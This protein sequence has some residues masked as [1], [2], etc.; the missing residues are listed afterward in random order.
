[1]TGSNRTEPDSGLLNRAADVKKGSEPEA[2]GQR[3]GRRGSKSPPSSKRVRFETRP[4]NSSPRHHAGTGAGK[5]E[6]KD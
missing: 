3:K 1:M 5:E 6:E 4:N 2:I